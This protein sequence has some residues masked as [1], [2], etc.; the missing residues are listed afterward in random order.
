MQNGRGVSTAGRPKRAFC[1][2]VDGYDEALIVYLLD[3]DRDPPRSLKR[4][5]RAWSSTYRWKKI[6]GIEFL[7]ARADVHPS[8]V[9][10]VD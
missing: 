7:Y 9:A 5:Y 6:Y 3:L 8:V 4:P 10:Y 2:T 1:V